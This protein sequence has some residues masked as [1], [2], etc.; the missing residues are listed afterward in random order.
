MSKRLTYRELAVKAKVL[1]KELQEKQKDLEQARDKNI[2]NEKLRLFYKVAS[3]ITHD[4]K[5]S[6]SILTLVVRNCLEKIKGDEFLE[7][8][9]EAIS[10]EVEKMRQL[11]D[12]FSNLHPIEFKFQKCNIIDLIAN[13]LIRFEPLPPDVQIVQTLPDLPLVYGDSKALETVFLN[14]IKNSL[15]AMPRGGRLAITAEYIEAKNSV[16]ITLADTGCG[17]SEAYLNNGLFKPFQ[18]P[19]IGG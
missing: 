7:R 3:F 12:I 10:N 14:V 4:L 17:I 2:E 6:T 15:E 5:N 18:P 13:V 1:R 9:F 16:K 11:M 8:S 19:R